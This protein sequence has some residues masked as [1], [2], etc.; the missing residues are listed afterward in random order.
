MNNTGGYVKACQQVV[1]RGRD[2]LYQKPAARGLF[3]EEGSSWL[4]TEMK[5]GRAQT[6][7][8]RT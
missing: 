4:S 3:S 8:S 6:R 7:T 1:K 2:S 5:C